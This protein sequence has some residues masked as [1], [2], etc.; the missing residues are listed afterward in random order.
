MCYSSGTQTAFHRN[1]Q[2]VAACDLLVHY[3]G[4]F[5]KAYILRRLFGMNFKNI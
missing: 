4:V 1:W 3:R 5:C 2:S